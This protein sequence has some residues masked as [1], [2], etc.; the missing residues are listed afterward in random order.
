[1]EK[2]YTRN[3]IE[4]LLVKFQNCEH[5]KRLDEY[6]S[7]RSIFDILGIERKEVQHSRFISWLFDDKDIGRAACR[8]LL[9]LL[10]KRARNF[11]GTVIPQEIK[12]AL[13]TGGMNVINTSA[14]TEV[15]FQDIK[16]I[17]MAGLI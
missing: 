7:R 16:I 4:D 9:I 17:P 15:P 14:T 2:E 3:E 5:R 1:M 12:D 6:F 11:D 13:L 10:L 8:H